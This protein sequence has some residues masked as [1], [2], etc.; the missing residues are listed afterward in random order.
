MH[1]DDIDPLLPLVGAFA[2]GA[3]LTFAAAALLERRRRVGPLSD[4]ILQA[5]VRARVGVLVSRPDL[6]EVQVDQGVVR[7]A[8]KVAA[9]EREAL[10]ISL[11][12]MP[13]VLRVRNALAATS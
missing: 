7:L 13:G 5:N 6:I 10:L 8:G 2:L 3:A 9:S 4:D 12:D 1:Y 11:L